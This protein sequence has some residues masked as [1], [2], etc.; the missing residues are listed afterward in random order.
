MEIEFNQMNS[1]I[2]NN[3]SELTK[4]ISSNPSISDAEHM[5]ITTLRQM[6]VAQMLHAEITLEVLKQ[7]KNSP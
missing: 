1:S 3:F 7:L 6:L 4:F 2:M 5:S